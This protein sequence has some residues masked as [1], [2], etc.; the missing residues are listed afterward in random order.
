[1]L[2]AGQHGNLT[3][4]QHLA[5]DHVFAVQPR[6]LD[7]SNEE[8]GAVGVRASIGHGKQEWASVLQLCTDTRD[9]TCQLAWTS[10]AIRRHLLKFSSSK[11]SP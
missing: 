6:S 2:A 9:M 1:M 4:L 7:S 10:T 3:Y 8:L 11:R 5:E